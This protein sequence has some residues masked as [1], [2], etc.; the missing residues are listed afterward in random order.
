MS[1]KTD[2]KDDILA[3]GNLRKY[4]M[5]QNNDG[6]VSFQ[7]VTQYEQTGDVF[8]AGDINKT[9]QAVNEK[10]DSGDVVDPMLTTEEGFAADAYKT[11]LQF[12]EQ[13]KN[14]TASDD[15]KFRFATDGEGNY[16][17]LKA[18]DSFIPFKQG[19]DSKEL[20][21]SRNGGPFSAQTISLDL[22]KYKYITIE[23]Y[24]E[25]SGNPSL[26]QILSVG[27]SGVICGATTSNGMYR[28]V[29]CNENGVTFGQGYW[30]SNGNATYANPFR[31]YGYK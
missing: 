14:L 9:N 31:I 18:D 25:G 19:I 20:L 1:L 23:C 13:N 27:G 16:G 5:I 26:P 3:A 28:S 17:Y 7:D 15:T 24:A 30:S 6:T 2:Y 29:S 10:F 11:K 21:W 22:S 12:D 4:Q 8:G